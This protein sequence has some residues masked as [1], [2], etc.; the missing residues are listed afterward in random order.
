MNMKKKL[1]RRNALRTGL[2]VTSALLLGKGVSASPTN[3]LENIFIPTDGQYACIVKH[4]RTQGDDL[5]V[6]SYMTV[7]NP[8]EML[9]EIENLRALSKFR[10]ELKYSNNDLF[11]IE[12]AQAVINTI[13]ES[14]NINFK[15]VVFKNYKEIFSGLSPN[16]YQQRIINMYR[17]LPAV[18]ATSVSFKKENLFGPSKEFSDAMKEVNGYTMIMTNPKSDS[19]IQI[20]D[21]VSG[22]VFA[23]LRPIE[24]TSET[25]VQLISFFK[26]K[27]NLPDVVTL[28]SFN[29][30]N[31]D[32]H[33]GKV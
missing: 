26:E 2:G 13:A 18:G 9:A 6:W 24:V 33:E 19:L 25:K 17:E 20:N 16:K 30:T 11:K 32:I 12:Y 8:D 22:I 14:S 10:S 21:F 7:N 3:F 15:M 1:S 23:L 4:G 31:I 29:N 5:M 28:D 27:M